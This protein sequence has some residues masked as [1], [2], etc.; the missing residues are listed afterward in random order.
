M[1]FP[2]TDNGMPNEYYF[3]PVYIVTSGG[4][5]PACLPHKPCNLLMLQM[6]TVVAPNAVR[7]TIAFVL[8]PP[9]RNPTPPREQNKYTVTVAATCI[10]MQLRVLATVDT[11]ELLLICHHHLD[12]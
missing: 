2:H 11:I 10:K 5:C 6:Q 1:N 3:N 12:H 7:D 8:Q 9:V 4:G